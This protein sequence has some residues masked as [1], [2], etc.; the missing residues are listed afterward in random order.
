MNRTLYQEAGTVT[1]PYPPQPQAQPGYGYPPQ[2]QPQYP[3][4]QPPG[5]YAPPAPY[6]PAPAAYPPA[7]YAPPQGY[8]PAQQYQQPAAPPPVQGTIDDF[9]NQPGGGS[10]KPL[11]FGTKPPGTAYRV[12][13]ARAV[14]SADIIHQTD[15]QTK[16]PQFFKDG[17]PRLVMV[18][19]VT[20]QPDH[21]YPEG[22]AS[23]WVKGQSRDELN[24]AMAAAGAPEGPPEA[25]AVLDIVKQG[26]RPIAGRSSQ[27]I[28]GVTY[29][30]PQGPNGVQDAPAQPQYPAAPPAQPQYAPQAPAQ[31]QYQQGQPQAP[32]QPQYAPQAPAQGQAMT[33]P[34]LDPAQQA[35]F[36]QLLAK[37]Q[38]QPAPQQ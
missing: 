12:T 37:Q 27:V 7:P 21:E 24:R 17:R 4:Q 9:Y 18:V 5:Q 34:G 2:Q 23:W 16:V 6:A 15:Q 3:A 20:L 8:A 33:P 30:R 29:W 19:P 31:P 28:Y 25:G 13:V 38:G 22:T 35:L 11:A 14:T 10:G 26:E 32:A 36:T 1:T